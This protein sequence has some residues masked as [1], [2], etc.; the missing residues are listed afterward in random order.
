M[1][2]PAVEAAQ[3]VWA[4]MFPLGPSWSAVAHD[5]NENFFVAAAREMAKTV[6]ELH[7][8]FQI[9]KGG[10]KF[11]GGCSKHA[12]LNIMW[13]CETAKRVYP[14]EELGL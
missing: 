9:L 7:T 11:C 14:S 5:G 10:R 1:S 2:D 3:R 12:D 8:P 4:A 13:P 6:Q